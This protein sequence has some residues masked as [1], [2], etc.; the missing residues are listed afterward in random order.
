VQLEFTKE[1]E[2]VY[3]DTWL[4][5]YENCKVYKVFKEKMLL[6]YFYYA[7]K[8]SYFSFHD[9]KYLVESKRNYFSKSQHC[10]IHQNTEQQVGEYKISEWTRSR[11]PIGT[12]IVDHQIYN[13][14][15]KKSFSNKGHQV[16]SVN[17]DFEEVI[18]DF[19][20]NMP[21]LT[22]HDKRER[23]FS[24]TIELDERNLFL[25]F[26]GFF[27]LEHSFEIDDSH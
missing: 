27:L 4:G 7:S 19:C 9:N 15:R 14:E 23:E 1:V 26:A 21:M 13:C 8:A 18:Y 17:N 5:N 6:G 11:S 20:I 2:L 3:N 12:L 24:G 22:F 16:I 10:I 25:A